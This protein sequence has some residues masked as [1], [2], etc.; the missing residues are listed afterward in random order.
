LSLF[1]TQGLA[2]WDYPAF[3][4]SHFT[5][6]YLIAVSYHEEKAACLLFFFFPV[7]Q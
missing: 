2:L 4:P 7:V 1:I 6:G 5:A 3:L